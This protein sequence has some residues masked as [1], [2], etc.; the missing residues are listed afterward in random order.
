[1]AKEGSDCSR[2]GGG[3]EINI[4]IC[5]VDGLDGE[6]KVG[7][8]QL[9]ITTK[10]PEEDLFLDELPIP[11]L[12]PLPSIEA[13]ASDVPDEDQAPT[14]NATPTG[15]IINQSG[16]QLALNN[17]DIVQLRAQGLEIDN[18]DGPAPENVGTWP[19]PQEEF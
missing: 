11:M 19:P 18:N 9:I 17:E 14:S 8:K 6:L 3:K 1:M 13:N 10:P 16:C 15:P 5:C 2:R 12:S 4:E 7:R